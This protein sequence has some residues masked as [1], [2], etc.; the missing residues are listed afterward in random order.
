MVIGQFV[1]L[2]ALLLI[3]FTLP[4]AATYVCCDDAIDC[5]FHTQ[6]GR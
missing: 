4:M 2:A 1:T 5:L 6:T 3:L